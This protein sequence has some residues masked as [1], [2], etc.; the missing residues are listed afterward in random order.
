MSQDETLQGET[1]HAFMGRLLCR[2]GIHKWLTVR[3][4]SKE[5]LRC[6]IRN[7]VRGKYCGLSVAAYDDASDRV[8]L[9]CRRLDFRIEQVEA[10]LRKE[11]QLI[12]DVL[13]DAKAK[14]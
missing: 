9:R 14:T 1:L 10:R 7:E 5:Y 6:L 13:K 12:F 4:E 11:E 8:C 2:L 3:N